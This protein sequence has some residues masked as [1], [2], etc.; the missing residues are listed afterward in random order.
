MRSYVSPSTGQTADI[1]QRASKLFSPKSSVDD[2]CH[3]SS[4]G[5][6]ITSLSDGT[7][8]LLG[9]RSQGELTVLNK[10]HAHDNEPWIAAWNY[11]DNSVIYSGNE[12]DF[13]RFHAMIPDPSNQAGTISR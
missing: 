8:S 12:P 4:L 3:Y 13:A 1:Q 6:L 10:W 9:P 11:W 7:L 2:G 5:K